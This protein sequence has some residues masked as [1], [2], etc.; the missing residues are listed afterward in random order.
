LITDIPVRYIVRYHTIGPCFEAF[1][2]G[3]RGSAIKKMISV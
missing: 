3:V 2:G 1:P